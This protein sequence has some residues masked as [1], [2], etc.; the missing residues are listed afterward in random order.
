[1]PAS[2]TLPARSVCVAERAIVPVASCT[3]VIAQVPSTATTA[4]PRV[5]I[6]VEPF[7]SWSPTSSLIAFVFEYNVYVKDLNAGTITQHLRHIR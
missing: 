6:A 2:L 7:A 3:L 5:T 4:V 1:M